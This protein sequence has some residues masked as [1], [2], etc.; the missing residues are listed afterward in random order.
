MMND[1]VKRFSYLKNNNDMSFSLRHKMVK[2]LDAHC[3][4]IMNYFNHLYEQ[5]GN[6]NEFDDK[7]Y[8]NPFENPTELYPMTC[9]SSPIC[10]DKPDE[11]MTAYCGICN[12]RGHIACMTEMPK[13]IKL[14]R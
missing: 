3:E 2:N 6:E 8:P 11:E 13:T 12:E 7:V 5:W 1:V 4:H 14:H 9:Q 10:K